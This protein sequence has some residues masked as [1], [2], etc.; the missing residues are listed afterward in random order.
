MTSESVTKPDRR[1]FAIQMTSKQIIITSIMSPSKSYGFLDQCE[2]CFI[3]W[4][5]SPI[6]QTTQVISVEITNSDNNGYSQFKH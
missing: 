4:T 6:K 2:P 3:E 1:T 5:T